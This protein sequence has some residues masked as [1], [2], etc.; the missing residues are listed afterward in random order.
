MIDNSQIWVNELIKLEPRYKFSKKDQVA[1]PLFL[2]NSAYNRGTIHKYLP[3]NDKAHGLGHRDSRKCKYVSNL[4]CWEPWSM[5]L[6]LITLLA[7][8]LVYGKVWIPISTSMKQG[9]LIINTQIVLPIWQHTLSIYEYI[10]KVLL[11]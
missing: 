1:V 7:T 11:Y 9:T 4:V 8:F 6:R 5:C 2:T 3:I 10:Y